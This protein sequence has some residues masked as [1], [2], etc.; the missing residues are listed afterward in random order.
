MKISHQM[1]PGRYT[2]WGVHL[3]SQLRIR[4]S[5]SATPILATCVACPWPPLAI[6]PVGSNQ[7]VV[8]RSQ[9]RTWPTRNNWR[10][11]LIWDLFGPSLSLGFQNRHHEV[12][13]PGSLNTSWLLALPLRFSNSFIKLLFFW[14]RTFHCHRLV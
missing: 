9:S 10:I 11:R 13:N 12:A 7:H 5:A 3:F 2:K 4:S 1:A 6:C 8:V 14:T